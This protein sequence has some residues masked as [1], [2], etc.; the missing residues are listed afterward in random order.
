M[1]YALPGNRLS[2][3]FKEQSSSLPRPVAGLSPLCV[4]SLLVGDD[5]VHGQA[6]LSKTGFRHFGSLDIGEAGCVVLPSQILN[7]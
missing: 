4:A 7:V 6:T 5:G 2:V 3:S 1:R